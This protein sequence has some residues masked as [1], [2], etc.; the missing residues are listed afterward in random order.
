MVK[1]PSS[2]FGRRFPN[3]EFRPNPGHSSYPPGGVAGLLTG[4]RAAVYAVP[5]FFQISRNCSGNSIGSK[6]FRMMS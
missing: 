6:G 3:F 5:Q 1:S 2:D 4:K